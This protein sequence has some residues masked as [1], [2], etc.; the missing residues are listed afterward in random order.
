MA[1]GSFLNFYTNLC[2]NANV[3][4]GIDQP[5]CAINMGMRT[6]DGLNILDLGLAL[7]NVATVSLARSSGVGAAASLTC[8]MTPAHNVC[9]VLASGRGGDQLRSLA[10]VWQLHTVA[11]LAPL[12]CHWRHVLRARRAQ[13]SCVSS[14]PLPARARSERD[15]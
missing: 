5:M 4:H 1:S 11:E 9:N 12:R 15:T 6:L 14:C 3:R 7:G 10:H 2:C 13:A 8:L